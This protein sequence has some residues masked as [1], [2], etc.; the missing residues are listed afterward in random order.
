MNLE[1]QMKINAEKK[2]KQDEERKRQAQE[3]ADRTKRTSRHKPLR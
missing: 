2:K 1:E 3:L